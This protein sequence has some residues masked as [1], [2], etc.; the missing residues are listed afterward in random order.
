[1][2]PISP[3]SAAIHKQVQDWISTGTV[4]SAPHDT[5]WNS[6]LLR[7][8]KK[9]ALGRHSADRICIDPRHINAMLKVTT[10]PLPDI[11]ALLRKLQGLFCISTL[12][13]KAAFTQCPVYEPHRPILSFTHQGKHYMFRGTPYGLTPLSGHYQRFI[14]IYLQN[15]EDYNYCDFFY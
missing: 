11:P 3:T 13:I 2:S 8:R 12:D 10:Y 4:V 14:E 15:C 9:D 6:P 7:V 5:V 1:M